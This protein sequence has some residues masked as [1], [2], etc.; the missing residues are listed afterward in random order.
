MQEHFAS[1]QEGTTEYNIEEQELIAHNEADN[2]AYVRGKCLPA[3]RHRKYE[4][5]RNMQT[6]D[7][8]EAE[9]ERQAKLYNLSP[10]ALLSIFL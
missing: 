9:L 4:S 6:E 10:N 1:A 2:E 3:R 8:E 5:H 7:L